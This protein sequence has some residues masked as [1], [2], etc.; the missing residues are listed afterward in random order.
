M[1]T[2]TFRL[3][4]AL[5]LLVAFSSIPLAAGPLPAAEV[6]PG[7]LPAGRELARQLDT[8]KVESRWLR[9]RHPV[10][11]RTGR[12]TGP[13]RFERPRTRCSQF[14]AVACMRL[15]VYLLRPPRHSPYLLANAQ[16]TWL[17]SEEGR[18]AGWEPLSSGIEA[19]ARANQGWLVVATCRNPDPARPGHIALVRPEIRTVQEVRAAGPAITQAGRENFRRTTLVRGFRNHPGA[20]EN[21]EIRYFA[22]PMQGQGD[23]STGLEGGSWVRLQELRVASRSTW[24]V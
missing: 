3:L 22:H 12:A 7:V 15:G 11:W 4:A 8:L 1:S 20:F 19:Q 21:D 6:L 24:E 18:K 17:H 13:D 9:G 5:L 14:A 2:R 16:F 10:D 23:A